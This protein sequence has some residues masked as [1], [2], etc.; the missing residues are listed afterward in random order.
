MSTDTDKGTQTA[1]HGTKDL[2][3]QETRMQVYN[4]MPPNQKRSK[5]VKLYV[6]A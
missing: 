4:N 5:T 6:V 1:T 2:I 3:Q